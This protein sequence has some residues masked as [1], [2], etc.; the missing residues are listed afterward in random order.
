MDK[1]AALRAQD[2]VDL[3]EEDGH[4]TASS[5]RERAR[6]MRRRRRSGLCCLARRCR[7]A[8][9]ETPLRTIGTGSQVTPM[10]V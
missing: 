6:V 5:K 4:S 2:I 3:T 9:F 1:A 8:G 10:E 7:Y